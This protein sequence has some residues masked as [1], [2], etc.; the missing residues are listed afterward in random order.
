[1]FFKKNSIE[2]KTADEIN[3]M[4]VAGR[5]VGEVLDKLSSIIKPGIS[6]K[7]ID[8]FSEKYIRSK[9]MLPAFLGVE[10][11]KYPF[12]ATACVSVND[13]VVHGVPSSSRILRSGDIVSVDVGAFYDGYY[14]DAAKTYPV[15]K[16]S[17]S[18]LNL[19]RITE[20]SLYESIK[21]ALSGNR[22]GDISNA[23]QR[24]AENAGY[25]VVRDFVGHGIGRELHEDPPIPN[26]GQ[27]GIGLKLTAGMVLAIEPMVNIG[28]YKVEMLDN[29]WTIATKDGSLSAHFEHTVAITENGNEILTKV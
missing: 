1:M 20:L 17:D 13:E 7:D 27:A 26:F 10:G 29:D 28:G 16:V 15:G 2:T 6:T 18:A 12:P 24:T 21:F 25:S 22:L 9:N 23:V 8:K 4:R 3:K 11:V 14:G 5:V 19:L